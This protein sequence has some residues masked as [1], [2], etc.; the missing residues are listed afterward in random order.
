MARSLENPSTPDALAKLLGGG[1]ETQGPFEGEKPQTATSKKAK[2][3]TPAALPAGK[4]GQECRF[5][6][7]K[8]KL[9]EFSGHIHDA[10]NR[11]TLMTLYCPV[12]G[13]VQAQAS[14]PDL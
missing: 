5:K 4:M 12:C 14:V 6:P 10:K 7:C 1:T 3:A 11:R 9:R 13:Q 8:G 2:K